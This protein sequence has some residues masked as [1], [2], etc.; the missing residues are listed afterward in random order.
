MDVLRAL[1]FL[2]L[3]VRRVLLVVR[4]KRRPPPLGHGGGKSRFVTFRTG[5]DCVLCIGRGLETFLG[6]A[7][8]ME[9]LETSGSG[10][11]FSVLGARSSRCGD[12]TVLLGG[13]AFR[14]LLIVVDRSRN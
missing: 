10:R 14:S 11:D 12:G 5:V 8:D 1:R 3:V 4:K 6:I 2:N 7:R 9:R 13:E